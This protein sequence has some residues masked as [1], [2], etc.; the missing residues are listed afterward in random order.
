MDCDKDTDVPASTNFTFEYGK[1][2]LFLSIK[3]ENRPK[4]AL[5]LN[6]FLAF[7]IIR[8][9][10]FVLRVHSFI[11]AKANGLF[12]HASEKSKHYSSFGH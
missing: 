12:V 9:F 10:S 2:V 7:E 11:N 6:D 8:R 3:M 1:C 4:N 5:F